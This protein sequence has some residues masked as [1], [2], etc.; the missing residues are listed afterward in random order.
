MATVKPTSSPPVARAVAGVMLSFRGA[1]AAFTD[2]RPFLEQH[3]H[4]TV[5]Q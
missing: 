4:A 5:P 2:F 1:F 3:V